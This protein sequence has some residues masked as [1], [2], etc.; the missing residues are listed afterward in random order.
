MR[1]GGWYLWLLRKTNCTYLYFLH[2][3]TKWYMV[4]IFSCYPILVVLFSYEQKQFARSACADWLALEYMLGKQYISYTIT[5]GSQ[6]VMRCSLP[7]VY[8]W[9]TNGLR[10]FPFVPMV[11]IVR[12]LWRMVIFFLPMVP[13]VAVSLTRV[14]NYPFVT[15]NKN[16]SLHLHTRTKQLSLRLI[17]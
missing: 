16:I 4:T 17:L 11:R 13:L 2:N 1:G 10:S 9:Y 5:H 7:V 12:L 14:S 6:V 8:Q 3:I 15:N